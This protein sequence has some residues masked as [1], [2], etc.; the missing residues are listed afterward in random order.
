MRHCVATYVSDCA[1][2]RT[3]IWSMK[4]CQGETRRRVLTIEVLPH[5][6]TIWQARG[7]RDSPPTEIA[8]RMLDRWAKQEGLTMRE[9]L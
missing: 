3:S 2:R 7:R 5:T 8:E 4:V 9:R 1:R 6:R